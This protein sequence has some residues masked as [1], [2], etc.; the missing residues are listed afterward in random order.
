MFPVPTSLSPSRVEAFTSCPMQFRFSSIEKL[1]EP[2][3][4]HTSKGTLVHRVLELLFQQPAG[5]RTVERALELFPQA[6]GEVSTSDEYLRMGLEQSAAGTLADEGRSLVERYF[7]IEDPTTIEP[8]G[9]ELKLEANLG[10]LQLRGI[11]DRLERAPDGTLV[12]TDYK[13]GRAPSPSYE[14]KRLGGVHFYA[15]LVE[16][17]LG[18]RPSSIRLVYV[19]SSKVISTTPTEQSIN[20]LPKRTA[21]VFSAIEKACTSGNFR[22]S[23]GPLCKF[24][25]FQR[26]CPE[27]GGDPALAAAEAPLVYAVPGQTG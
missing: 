4:V 19:P 15:W 17:A 16:Q 3:S 20:F 24:C 12:V 5:E 2:A 18:E 8:V 25:A 6:W 11:I 1:P 21:A 13:T 22:T 14:Q 23:P 9:L 7:T 27:F 26:W 10:S